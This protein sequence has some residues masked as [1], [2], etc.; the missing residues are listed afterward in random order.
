MVNDGGGFRNILNLEPE[1]SGA[2]T[3]SLTLLSAQLTQSGDPY[4]VVISGTCGVAN[5]DAVILLVEA[6]PLIL[7]EPVSDAICENGFTI[8]NVST[9]GPAGMTYQWYVDRNTGSFVPLTDD[10]NHTGS[11]MEQLSISNA[12][13]SMNGWRYQFEVSTACM[14][15]LSEIVTLTVWDNPVPS[16]TPLS[17]SCR[18]SIDLRW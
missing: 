15:V 7:T 3:D 4:M 10:L 14:P 2:T 9:S 11:N 1:Y 12:Q 17:C 6:D 16:I 18:L 5:S 8:F 13:V